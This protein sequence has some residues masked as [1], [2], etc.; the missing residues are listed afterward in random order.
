MTGKKE[1]WDQYHDYEGLDKILTAQTMRSAE[2][3]NPVHDEMLFIIFHQVYELWF[4]Q[5]LFEMDDIQRRLANDIVDDR[6]MQPILQYLNRIVVIFRNM[7]NMIDI[8]ETMPPQAFVDFRQYLSTASGFQSWQFRLIEVRL[9]LKREDRIPVFHADFDH[10]LSEQSKAHIRN[11][12]DA[13]SLYDQIDRWLSRTPFTEWQDYK[14]WEEYRGAVYKMFDDKAAQHPQDKDE[15][16][17]G[18]HKFDSIFDEN[19]HADAQKQ[20]TWRMSLKALQAALFINIYSNE[21]ILQG[22]AQLLNSITDIDEL[23]ARWRYR[24]ALM[25][26]RMV[27]MGAGTGGSSGYGY[28]MET[29][30]KHRIFTD[31]FALSSYL[32]PSQALPPLPE[33]ISREM[34]YRYKAQEDAA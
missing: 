4:K 24:H 22:P 34:G 8:L 30:Q 14:F 18:R 27:G 7:L 31:L 20:G 32:I 21:P 12:E 13:P 11:A 10:D 23:L 16:E 29:L 17:R 1:P 5:I 6:D 33:Q 9:G 25:V 19:K 28:L 15:I 26:Q 2:A 3:G